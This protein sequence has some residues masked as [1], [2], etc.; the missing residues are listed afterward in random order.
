[1]LLLLAG[2]GVFLTFGLRFMPQRKLGYGFKMLWQGRSSTEKGDI[3][4]FNALM[5]AL[6]ATIGTGNIAGVATAIFYG[7][8]GAIFWMWLIALI[9]MAT[10]F[11]EA[12]LAVHFREVDAKGHYVG[13][14]MYYIRN[15]LGPNWK[16]LGVIFAIFGM[17]AGFGIGNSIQAHSVADVMQSAFSVPP[18]LTGIIIALLVGMVLLGGIKRIGD[19]AGKLV[20]L[21]AVF[22]VGGGLLVLALHID[23]IPDAISLI[24]YHAFNPT[25]AAGGFA[26]AT[27][28]AA[29]RFGVA[30]GIFSNE[31]GLGSAPIAHATAKTDSP[32]RQGTVAML[33]T[34]LDT[35]VVCTITALVIVVTGAWQSGENGATLSAH[36]F[37]HGLGPVGRYIV[38]I[39]V[40]LFA[41]TTII[42]WSFYSEKCAQFLFGERS[43]FPFRLIWVVVIPIGTLP[44]MDLGSLWL[45]ADTLN[46]LM[47]IPN[48]IALLLLSPVVFKLTKAYF[49]SSAEQ[50]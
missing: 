13:G 17:F 18:L 30:R 5:T 36:A 21:M 6:S 49:A 42:G 48:L 7:G 41:F 50:K 3:S 24:L 39:G 27:V 43:N 26:G 44:G 20:P 32:I 40:A 34:F 28:W 8:P 46:A 12:T 25:A 15:G 29:I 1:M 14:P 19:V 16:W 38:S 4:P 9:G 45:V 23:R 37:S 10:K 22:Y 11:C 35:I 47:A 2:T 33:G 31:A